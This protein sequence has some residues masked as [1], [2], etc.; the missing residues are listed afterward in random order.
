DRYERSLNPWLRRG[1]LPSDAAFH[2]RNYS[3]K[4]PSTH[5]ILYQPWGQNPLR[6]RNYARSGPASGA[7]QY[8]RSQKLRKLGQEESGGGSGSGSHQ[9]GGAVAAAHSTLHGGRPPSAGPVAGHENVG[10]GGG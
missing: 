5:R 3:W 10:H 1:T 8:E 9:L 4:G 2:R 7:A 6:R